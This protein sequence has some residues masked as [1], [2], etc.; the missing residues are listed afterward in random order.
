M[1]IFIFL[2]LLIS[3]IFG[4]KITNYDI[5]ESSDIRISQN[6]PNVEPNLPDKLSKVEGA[7]SIWSESTDL[8]TVKRI[9]YL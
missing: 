4:Q 3:I 2:L 9:L 7:S 8:F 5:I 6:N 1:K